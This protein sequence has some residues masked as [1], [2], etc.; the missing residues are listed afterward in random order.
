MVILR[1]LDFHRLSY[2][3]WPDLVGTTGIGCCVPPCFLVVLASGLGRT[4]ICCRD[5][6]LGELRNTSRD[7]SCFRGI[8]NGGLWEED[9]HVSVRIMYFPHGMKV[10]FVR[11]PGSDIS[12]FLL[13]R[14]IELLCCFIELLLRFIELLFRY[15]ELIIAIYRNIIVFYRIIITI[16]RNNYSDISTYYCV[17]TKWL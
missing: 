11:S 7:S 5:R 10:A 13:L 4:L 3:G 17:L 9:L 6:G 12:L 15:I 16:Y 14:F 8:Y 2:L 1:V